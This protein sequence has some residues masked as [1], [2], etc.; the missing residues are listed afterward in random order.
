MKVEIKN[1]ACVVTSEAGDLKFYGTVNAVGESALLYHIKKMLNARGYDL[2][3][4]RMYK[5]GHMVDDM[6]QY[7]RTRKPS[8]DPNKDIYI[9]NGMWAIAGAND[10]LNDSGQVTLSIMTD[11]FNV[12][13]IK[14]LERK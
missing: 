12:P 13:K 2:I 14:A 6:Q 3:K 5:D 8:G 1:N 4:K 9:W 10:Y 11:I 7:L